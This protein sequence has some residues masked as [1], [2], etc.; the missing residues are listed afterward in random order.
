MDESTFLSRVRK[1]LT[2]SPRSEPPGDYSVARLSGPD[3]DLV[4]RFEAM[5]SDAGMQVTRLAGADALPDAVA[6]IVVGAGGRLV[7]CP[8]EDFPA[9]ADVLDR[10]RAGGCRIVEEPGADEVFA[11]DVGLT[12]AGRGVA[13][14]GSIE[15]CSGST[16]A[17]MA[18]L[19]PPTHVAVLR[20]S[21]IVPDLL[22]WAQHAEELPAHAALVTGPSKSADIELTLVTGVHGPG[23][24]FVLVVE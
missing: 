23:K 18:S 3:A 5:A 11:A 9:R 1:A 6:Q 22:D 2:N 15:L 8:P 17:R 21:A 24:V 7:F 20:A 12:A 10:L 14:T 16:A 19:A 4:A 13:E